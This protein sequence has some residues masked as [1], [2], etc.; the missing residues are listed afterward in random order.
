MEFSSCTGITVLTA[1]C[2]HP[3]TS[4]STHKK[5]P[6]DSLTCWSIVNATVLTQLCL[7][8]VV[9]MIIIT[10]EIRWSTYFH[11]CYL[12]REIR[13]FYLKF[14]D[15]ASF[16]IIRSWVVLYQSFCQHLGI[17]LLEDIF[18]FN[19]LKHNHLYTCTWNKVLRNTMEMKLHTL[20]RKNLQEKIL[21]FTDI[22]AKLFKAQWS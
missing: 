16:C 21:L 20:T 9:I 19:V 6:V 13:L 18:V 17:E 4:N 10:S 12:T 8:C 22:W 5:R 3:F 7:V 2:K 15:H 1:S 11:Y 14:R